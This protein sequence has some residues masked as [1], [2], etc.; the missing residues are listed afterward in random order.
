[1]E[2][3]VSFRPAKGKVLYDTCG[4]PNRY[5]EVSD[6]LTE[7]VLRSARRSRPLLVPL[8]KA[9]TLC[10]PAR[11]EI[12]IAADCIARTISA[13]GKGAI[14]VWAVASTAYSSGRH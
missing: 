13:P 11:R 1:M 4:N 9:V 3:E 7:P 12:A 5:E 8:Y 14:A 2:A 10:L 6:T